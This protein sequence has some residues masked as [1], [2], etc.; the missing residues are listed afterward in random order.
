MN[1]QIAKGMINKLMT[2]TKPTISNLDTPEPA[3][4]LVC[5]KCGGEI[6]YD[7]CYNY[8]CDDDWVERFYAGHCM[9]CGTDH[10]WS[11]LYKFESIENLRI[12]GGVD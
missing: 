12:E 10:Q 3:N 5:L 11:E 7:D 6:E 4:K 1:E 9:D 8:D 2:D